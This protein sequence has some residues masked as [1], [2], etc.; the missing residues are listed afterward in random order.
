ML[1]L[2]EFR[3][4]K[5]EQK[6]TLNVFDIDSTLFNSDTKVF[7]VKNGKTVKALKSSEFNTYQLKPGEEFDFSQFRS[8]QHFYNT[9]TP[10]DKMI[11]RAQRV[12][13]KQNADDKTVIITAR[14]DFDDKVLFLQKF[15]EHGFPIDQVYVERAGN[16][17]KLKKSV[18][19]HV[20]KGVV[21]KKYLMTGKYN[22]VKMWDDTES[23]HK[24]LMKVG[25]MFP[26]VEVQGY[27][28][29]PETGN[30]ERYK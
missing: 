5:K 27:L 25:S 21:L 24:T 20:T 26:G 3:E 29:N 2:N 4:R 14:A 7:V 19:I 12:V 10:I 18:K 13:S 28:V 9:A 17:E 22:L 23:N 8:A 11:G 15:R 1:R 30:S 16:L 6:G